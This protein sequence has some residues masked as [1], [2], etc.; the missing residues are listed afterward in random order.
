M[1]LKK[2]RYRDIFTRWYFWLAI[3]IYS[4]NVMLSGVEE[5]S[6]GGVVR[7]ILISFILIIPFFSVI[8]IIRWVYRKIKNRPQKQ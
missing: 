2:L 7:S 8:W 5:F 1:D 3:I 4:L 6:L